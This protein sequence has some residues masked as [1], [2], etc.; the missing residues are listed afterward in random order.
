MRLSLSFVC[1]WS[2]NQKFMA[3]QRS[4]I[5]VLPVIATDLADSSHAPSSNELVVRFD[6][7]RESANVPASHINIH[8]HH[9]ELEWIMR[10]GHTKSRSVKKAPRTDALHFPTGGHRFRPCLEDVLEALIAD[11]KLDVAEEG[12]GLLRRQRLTF[13]QRQLAAAVGDDAECAAQALR[14]L[15]Y[16][17]TLNPDQ[18]APTSRHDR[19]E[20]L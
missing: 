5:Q 8:S 16:D 10:R 3:I 2:A 14:E 17:V 15:G 19:L 1:R 11:F 6:Y 18:E 4:S 9:P 12:R 20:A 7:N 13:R